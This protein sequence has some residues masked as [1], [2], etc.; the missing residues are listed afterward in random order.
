[1]ST[2]AAGT[3]RQANTSRKRR[4]MSIEV[5]YTFRFYRY[6]YLF[7]LA[8]LFLVFPF[9]SYRLIPGGILAVAAFFLLCIYMAIIGF[10]LGLRYML[11]SAVSRPI[12]VL[13][14]EGILL[15]AFFF[16]PHFLEWDEV[17]SV[18][19][20]EYQPLKPSRRITRGIKIT[21]RP[22][23]GRSS[24]SIG[25]AN[26]LLGTIVGRIYWIIK[27]RKLRLWFC[28]RSKTIVDHTVEEVLAAAGRLMPDAQQ[29]P[30]RSMAVS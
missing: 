11:H 1:V 26:S 22:K 13:K 24:W 14:K 15:Y 23:P 20:V 6:L 27:R 28:Q 29:S 8:A 7:P 3:L 21:V 4:K 16:V 19:S 12:L 9:A 2:A 17:A 18:G 5:R 25:R 30:T 10:A